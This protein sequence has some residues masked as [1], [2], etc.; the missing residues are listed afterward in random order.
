MN[1]QLKRKNTGFHIEFGD[2]VI[3]LALA[4]FWLFLIVSNSAFQ[5]FSIFATIIKEASMY[6][7]CG[8]GM[9]YAMISGEMDMSVASMIAMLSVIFTKIVNK[10]MPAAPGMGILVTCMII[11]VLSTLCGVFNGVL[12]AK[13]RIPSFIATLAMQNIYRG[14][15]QLIS[16]SPIPIAT[17]GKEYGVFTTGVGSAVKIGQIS[18][19]FSLLYIK[20]F[21]FTKILGLPLFFWLMVALAIIGTIILHKTK[22]GRN[23]VAIG[24]SKSA[25]KIAGINI[26]RTQISVFALLGLFTGIT[27]LMM[28]SNLGSSNYGV[29]KGTEFIVISAVVLG[30]TVPSGGKGN[31]FNTV[32]AAMFMATISTALTTFG[33]PNDYYGIFR[34]CILVIAFS[35]NTIRAIIA[36]MSVKRN[37]RKEAKKAAAV[38]ANN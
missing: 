27:A 32:I 19:K 18:E 2:H 28:T 3:V 5:K 9:T 11:L 22:L 6:A 15:A 24:N 16:D 21:S 4:I 38:N 23:I 35:I 36:D 14:I 33:V 26:P 17:L 12:I 25:S 37:A 31:V 30:G 29:P 8:I 13:L 1:K 7:V 10:I 34:G 20:G